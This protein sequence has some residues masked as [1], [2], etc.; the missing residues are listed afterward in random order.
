LSGASVSGL[1]NHGSLGFPVLCII[2]LCSSKNIM[3][4]Q[5]VVAMAKAALLSSYKG[6]M[7]AKRF[8]VWR[9]LVNR[10]VLRADFPSEA[11]AADSFI[12]AAAVK[13]RTERAIF[14]GFW[15]QGTNT[16]DCERLSALV[17]TVKERCMLGNKSCA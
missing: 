15:S 3:T 2:K 14:S 9:V 12:L 4:I 5:S 7:I 16:P 11:M 8:F 6:G 13:N 17:S 10:L 1:G